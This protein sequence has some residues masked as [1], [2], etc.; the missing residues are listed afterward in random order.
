VLRGT[1]AGR[2]K[3]DRDVAGKTGTTND[4]KDAWFVGY[5]P[6]LV[7]GLYIG[8]DNPAPLGHGMTGGQ[9]ASPVF[10]TFMNEAVKGT[11]PTHFIMP[12]GMTRIAVNRKTGM[13]ATEGEPDAIDEFFKPGTGPADS[14]MVIGAEST[15]APEEILK[16]SPQANQAV[17]SG[18]GGLF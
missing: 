9:L 3:L 1:A 6:D 8:Y 11:P 18:G 2:V 7:A 17:T 16:A 14:Y 12:E 10:N 13:Q 4:E 5:T 15:L